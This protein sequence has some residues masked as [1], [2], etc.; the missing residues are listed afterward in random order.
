M[1]PEYI[2]E[3]WSSFLSGIDA[4]ISE[5]V[6]FHCLGGFV[7]TVV[8]GFERPTADVDVLTVVPRGEVE[9][10]IDLA[11]EAPRSTESTASIWTS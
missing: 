6:E 2:P 4:D 8:Y 11:A 9:R 10:L 5:E 3:P 7:V 1:P